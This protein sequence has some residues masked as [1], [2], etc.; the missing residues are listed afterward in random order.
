MRTSQKS[1]ATSRIPVWKLLVF[2]L[3]LSGCSIRP[4]SIAEVDLELR[5]LYPVLI[6][7]EN[8]YEP[9]K[10]TVFIQYRRDT[11]FYH[12]PFNEF[13]LVGMEAKNIR[14]KYCYFIY[15]QGKD[16]GIY[17]YYLD[18]T[19]VFHNLNVDSVLTHRAFKKELEIAGFQFLK[20]EIREKK[21]HFTDR[22]FYPTE[23][24]DDLDSLN[25][26][27]NK[28]LIHLPFSLSPK[29][30]SAQHSKLYKIHAILNEQQNSIVHKPYPK[31]EYILEFEVKKNMNHLLLDSAIAVLRQRKMNF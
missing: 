6:P 8:G 11:V 2:F 1:I 5:V 30:D 13:D 17:M 12:I 16:S 20:R 23:L 10:D 14:R 19:S 9:I 4:K 18:T 29:L 26:S 15:R 3:S 25:L 21:G 22:Y 7:T 28:E 27:Y 24:E 31:R